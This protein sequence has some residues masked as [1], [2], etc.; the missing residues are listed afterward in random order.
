VRCPFTP[1]KETRTRLWI[2]DAVLLAAAGGAPAADPG[3]PPSEGE[4]R[5][6]RFPAIHGKQIVFTYAGL[7]A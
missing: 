3:P 7:H 6:L 1:T 4:A 2:T 5:L